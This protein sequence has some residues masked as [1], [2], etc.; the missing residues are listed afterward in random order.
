MFY[1]RE[2]LA[3]KLQ[4]HGPMVLTSF[5]ENN[6]FQLVELLIAERKWLEESPSHAFPFR[7]TQSVRKSM[8]MGL[9]NGTSGLRSLFLSRTSQSNLQKSFE[10]EGDKHSQTT[11]QTGVSRPATET[12]YTEKSRNDIL[13]D[14]QKL[15]ADILRE[16]P[17]G[18]NIGCFRK[19]FAEKYGYHLDIKKLG[20]QKMAYLI[21]IMPGVKLELT[22]MYP[23][24]PAVCVSDSDTSILKTRA[25]NASNE[26]FNS[27]NELSDTASKEYYTESPWEELGPVSIKSSSQNDL[28]SNLTQKAIE[29]NTPKYPD[30]EPIVSDY[31]SSE[32]EGDNSC[33]TRSEDQVKPKHDEQDSSF[34][35]ALD[36]WHSSKEEENSVKKSENIDV[37][38]NSLLDILNSAP[39]SKQ[40]IHGIVSNKEKQRSHKYSFVV[41]PAS[42][43]KDKFIGG[44]LDG[45]KK[46]DEPKIHN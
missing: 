18:Y 32:S 15:V 14:C 12:K 28:E 38:G 10:Y 44:I 26:K 20:Y 35:Q 22:Y 25:T 27:Y 37:L 40:G 2:D 17:E 13:Q 1:V 23:S 21:Q 36:T 8:P 4:K 31:D 16:H 24:S 29:L 9:S 43:D 39:D 5:P 33:S 11:Q 7:L 19:Q 46:E 45:L 3:H 6:I 41:D 42:P 34:W 30:Y